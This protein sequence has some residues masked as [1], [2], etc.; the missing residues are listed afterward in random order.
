MPNPP[1]GDHWSHNVDLVGYCDLEAKPAFKLAV[2]ERDGR[3]YLYVAHLWHRGWSIVDVTDPDAPKILRFIDGPDNTWTIQIQI[4]ERRMITALEQINTRWG[5]DPDRPNDEGVLIWDLSDPVDPVPLGH[6]KTG[7]GGTHRNFYDGGRTMHLTAFAPGYDGH[8]YRIVDIDD[9]TNP[10]EVGRWWVP[11][12]WTE[13]G[14][15]GAPRHTD[16]HG[17]P[18]VEGDRAYLPYGGAGFITLDVSDLARPMMLSQLTFAPP[19]PSFI[20]LHTALP[21]PSRDLAVVNSEAIRENCDEPLG[22]VG[23]VDIEDETAPRLISTFPVPMPPPEAPYRNFCQHGGRFGPHN[24][25]QA[26]HQR[27]LMQRNDL[28]FMAYFNAG[29]RIFDISDALLPRE[30]GYF[31]PPDPVERRGLM[32]TKLV[33]QS[34]DVLVD[35]RGYIYIS[36]KNHGVYILKA[37]ESVYETDY[38][39]G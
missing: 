3:W 12:Q 9:P 29:L 16:L 7:A 33:T 22:L 26:Q 20:G 30:V 23:L 37:A 1:P 25:H 5:G 2:D 21:I 32:P 11:G 31:V 13:G 34:E 6:F 27:V 36:D 39:P 38:A 19:F 28:V 4:A 35:A 17:G 14:E 15:T 10:T 24:Q 18:Y 8:I